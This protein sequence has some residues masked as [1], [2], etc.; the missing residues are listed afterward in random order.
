MEAQTGVTCLQA[1]GREGSPETS[2]TWERS[3]EQILL[4]LSLQEEPAC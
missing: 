3:A 1:K 2:R 4:P